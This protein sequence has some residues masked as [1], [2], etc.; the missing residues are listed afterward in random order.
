MTT[1]LTKA[2]AMAAVQQ[3][4][5]H[6]VMS[7]TPSVPKVAFRMTRVYGVPSIQE[8]HAYDRYESTR[9]DVRNIN[10]I[11]TAAAAPLPLPTKIHC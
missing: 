9:L 11:V 2:I 7:L 8:Q 1:A 4:F 6:R 3:L 10:N 5:S